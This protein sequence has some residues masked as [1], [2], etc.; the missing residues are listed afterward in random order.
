MEFLNQELLN[1]VIEIANHAGDEIMKIYQRDFETYTKNDESPLTEA[2]LESHKVICNGLQQLGLDFPIMSEE[3]ATESW[4]K[5][6]TWQTYWLIDPIDGTKEFIK[7]NGEFTV[8]IAL[9]HEHKSVL[10]VVYAPAK[11][12]LY[13]AMESFGSYLAEDS[14]PAKKLEVKEIDSN[15]VVKVVG[16]RSHTSPDM[17]EYLTQFPQHEMVAMGSSLKLCAVADGTADIYPRLGLTSEWDTGAAQCVVE[18][19]G[20]QVLVHNTN[21]PLLYNAKE[22]ILNPY[23]IVKR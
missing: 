8:N 17:A 16:S 2:D 11:N 7:K 3:S 5:R 4:D 9:I 15:K 19:A 1:K 23:F 6:Q 10:G 20:A 14:N 21:E 13:Y 18:Q 12:K 22:D